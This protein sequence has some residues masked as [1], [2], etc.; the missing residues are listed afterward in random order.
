[1]QG[2]QCKNSLPSIKVVGKEERVLPYLEQKSL[3]ILAATL[4][5]ANLLKEE[6]EEVAWT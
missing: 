5:S 2:G 6:Q 1:M 3:D 4:H